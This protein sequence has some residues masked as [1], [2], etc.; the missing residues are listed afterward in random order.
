[1]QRKNSLKTHILLDAVAALLMSDFSDHQKLVD[2]CQILS[3]SARLGQDCSTRSCHW[4]GVAAACNQGALKRPQK[5][6]HPP[7]YPGLSDPWSAWAPGCSRHEVIIRP[8]SPS[9]P[10]LKFLGGVFLSIILIIGTRLSMHFPV[11][12]SPQTYR[13]NEHDKWRS[14]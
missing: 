9:S 6:L 2:Y 14:L 13:Y 7:I 4:R 1:M 8:M 10:Q 11:A 12:F 5:K 3:Q